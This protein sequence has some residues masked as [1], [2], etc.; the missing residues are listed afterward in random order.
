MIIII[1]RPFGRGIF[2]YDIKL[3]GY[4]ILIILNMKCCLIIKNYFGMLLD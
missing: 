1:P 3:Q 4:F 2:N